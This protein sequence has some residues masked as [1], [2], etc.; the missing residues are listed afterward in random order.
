MPTDTQNSKAS[1]TDLWTWLR[2]AT[3]SRDLFIRRIENLVGVG[4]PDVRGYYVGRP[5]D[6]ELKTA[7]RPK[8]PETPVIGKGYV[9]PEQVV[10]HRLCWLAGGNNYVLVQV[11]RGGGAK[12]YL[13]PGRD[14]GKIEGLSERDLCGLSVLQGSAVLP[15]DVILCA[16]T[17][18]STCE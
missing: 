11:G 4:D 6:I 7:A 15:L 17:Y 18:R 9:R 16:V 3:T 5:F 2:A 1:E 14:I 12:H 10:W 8:R 13:V